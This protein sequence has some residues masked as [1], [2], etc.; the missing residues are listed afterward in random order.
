[1]EISPKPPSP[2]TN[3]PYLQI[4]KITNH[5]LSTYCLIHLYMPTYIE[6]I[7]LIPIIQTTIFNH[8]H[9]NPLSNIIMLGD[10]NKDITLIGRQHGTTRTAST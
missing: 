8:I 7:N 9:N 1:V 10:F 4:I 2:Q 3:L 6:D 5:P